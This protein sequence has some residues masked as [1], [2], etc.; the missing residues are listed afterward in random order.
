[1]K[2]S[3][4]EDQQMVQDMA[5]DFAKSRIEPIAMEFDKSHQFPQKLI[6]EMGELGLMGVNI[7]EEYGGAGFDTVSYSLAVMEIAKGCS[8][9]AVTMS[10]NHLVCEIIRLYGSEE[11]KKKYLVPLASGD[12]LGAFCLTEPQAGSDA[13]N[14][15]T[16]AKLDGDDYILNGKKAFITNGTY[17]DVFIVTAVTSAKDAPKKEISAFLVEKDAE[18]LIL[19]Q[20]EHKMG[21]CA[22]NT[23]EVTL[24]NVRVPVSNMLAGTNGF[25]VMMNGLNSGRIGIA[26]L[27]CGLAS[28]ALDEALSYAKDRQAFG[29]PLNR[30]PVI[31]D[32]IA[33]MGTLLEASKLMTLNAAYVKDS[34][35][36]YVKSASMAKY[37]AAENCLKIVDQALQIHGGNG[38]ISEYKIEKLYR[39]ARITSIY[40]GTSEIQKIVI[41]RQM[42][43]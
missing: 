29:K 19:G 14:Q 43:K 11:N 34:G 16:T 12:H 1:M 33:E 30:L 21:Q 7:P 28:S 22:S 42:T 5:R 36:N 6:K 26:S 37:F 39:D 18:G 38:Y 41:A 32:K 8:S 3:L 4:S 13:Q 25:K 31:Q 17:S 15:K 35:S 40:E 23:I 2:F 20:P 27:C 24:E 10:V 9:F